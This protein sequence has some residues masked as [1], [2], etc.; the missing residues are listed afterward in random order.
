LEKQRVSSRHGRDQDVVGVCKNA[1][2]LALTVLFIRGGRLVG[3]KDFDFGL[4]REGESEAIR[5]FI[6][7]YYAKAHSIP[8]DILLGVT[9]D[10][11]NLLAEWLGDLRG[12]R[13][14]LRVPKR[15]DG[16]YLLEMA[17]R[18]AANHLSSLQAKDDELDT[19]LKR[20]Q[21]LLHLDG[22]PERLECV[23]ISNIQGRYGVG[24]LV[25]FRQGQP[26]KSSYRRYRIKS[27]DQA[28]D[29][30]MMA[31][32][33]NRRFT[34]EKDG[35]V[36]PDL[37]VVDGGKAQLNIALAL[38]DNLQLRGQV[39]V[40]ALAKGAKG[41]RAGE[42]S[43]E[44]LYLPGRKNPLSLQKERPLLMLMARLRDEA[45]RFAVSYYQRRHRKGTLRSRLDRV[46]G[47]G[48]K[49]RHVLL[50]HFGTVKDLA[51]ATPEEIAVV[52]GISHSLA[53]KIH[54]TLHSDSVSN[55]K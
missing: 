54:A 37:L 26:D 13:V 28:N 45:H 55:R 39:A 17:E 2:R 4:P 33:L 14:T 34:D 49:R 35:K 23:D 6:Q 18:N 1:D 30:A 40:I 48:P 29:T 11:Q 10:E 8:E 21:D 53:V 36:L 50:R 3:S 22:R 31:E 24:S 16:R 27:V 52:P 47:V 41:T 25:V 20:L 9:L 5:A 7:Q 44:K 12:K 15:G 46:S 32:V 38:M 42:N 43:V 51:R 19:A